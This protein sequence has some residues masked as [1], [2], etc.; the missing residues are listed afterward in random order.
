MGQ[1]LIMT[2]TNWNKVIAD[3]EA[4]GL[5]QTEFCTRNNL[6]YKEFVKQRCKAIAAGKFK[7]RLSSPKRSAEALPAF[8]KLELNLPSKPEVPAKPLAIEINLPNGINLKIPV[9]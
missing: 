4:S 8:S 1:A 2:Q 6:V 9:C 3:W 7:K 5:T